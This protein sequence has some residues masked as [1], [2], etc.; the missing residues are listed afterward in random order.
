MIDIESL[1]SYVLQLLSV[2]GRLVLFLAPICNYI[3]AR[4]CFV[5]RWNNLTVAGVESDD[6]EH[7]PGDLPGVDQQAA[8][9]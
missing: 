3:T 6:W 9:L 2:C 4:C 1:S 7:G 8:E 5:W